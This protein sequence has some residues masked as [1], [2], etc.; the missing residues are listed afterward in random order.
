MERSTGVDGKSVSSWVA[1]RLGVA[2]N[3][4]NPGHSGLN[5]DNSPIQ[6]CYSIRP[7]RCSARLVI[8][9]GSTA[10]DLVERTRRTQQLIEQQIQMHVGE[11]AVTPMREFVARFGP[12]D[13]EEAPL[14]PKGFGWFSSSHQKPGLALYIAPSNRTLSD[15]W[16]RIDQWFTAAG[17]DEDDPYRLRQA[18]ERIRPS[19]LGLEG[20]HISDLRLK[21][22][23]QFDQPRPFEEIGIN[24]F[25]S[26]SYRNFMQ[27]LVGQRN[28]QTKGLFFCVG[29]HGDTGA[30]VDTK[31]DI[32]GCS[33]CLNYTKKE[34]IEVVTM[35]GHYFGF[36]V[37]QVLQGLKHPQCR[38]AV[39]GM[40]QSVLGDLRLNVYLKGTSNEG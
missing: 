10:K 17:L 11:S 23:F 1:D 20:A 31:I 30:Q 21:L 7:D 3:D 5:V 26:E 40:G 36:D 4:S 39:I 14:F 18:R 38:L 25:L 35:L 19:A 15:T 28:I 12:K 37:T 24:D 8:D 16:K 33:R 27:M 6:L 9:P 32:C 13:D 22:Y 2:E 34:E 29:L